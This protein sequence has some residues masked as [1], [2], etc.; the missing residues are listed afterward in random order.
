MLRKGINEIKTAKIC[1]FFEKEYQIRGRNMIY[2]EIKRRIGD[3][4]R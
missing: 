3:N 2:A 4:K 1:K